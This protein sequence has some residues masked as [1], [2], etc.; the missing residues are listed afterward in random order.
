MNWSAMIACG[1]NH[2]TLTRAFEV[3]NLSCRRLLASLVAITVL[4][5]FCIEKAAARYDPYLS[6]PNTS[7]FGRLI[8]LNDE[9]NTAGG[10]ETK[11]LQ[12]LLLETLLQPFDLRGSRPTPANR[13]SLQPSNIPTASGSGTNLSR[14]GSCAV[15]YQDAGFSTPFHAFRW[16]QGTGPVDF[17]TLDPNN[18]ATLSSFA[19]DCNTTRV[20]MDFGRHGRPRRTSQWRPQFQSFRSKQ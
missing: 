20:P 6:D 14:D 15:G 3:K 16:T 10:T 19:T 12:T 9:L 5:F 8:I 11:T 2:K 4:T 1:H 7:F 17:G 13:V 18:N